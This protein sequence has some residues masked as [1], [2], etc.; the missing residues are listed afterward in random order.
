[1][2]FGDGYEE[3]LG[4]PID[5]NDDGT[6][7]PRGY[8]PTTPPA[9]S[10]GA[11]IGCI[12]TPPLPEDWQ[13]LPYETKEIVWEPLIPEVAPPTARFDAVVY[14]GNTVQFVNES[15]GNVESILWDFGD[16]QTST[17]QHPLHIYSVVGTFVVR[18]TISNAG[19][20]DIYEQEVTAA[21]PA[22]EVG[23][24]FGIGGYT[25]YFTNLSNTTAW[26][27]S[28]GDGQTS[29]DRNPKHI[30][31]AT[32][33]YEVTLKTAGLVLKKTIK[34]D[35]EILLEWDDNSGDED[36]FK[37]ERSPDGST[38]WTE[39]ADVAADTTSYGITQAKDGVD[40]V[41]MNFFRVYAYSGGGDSGYSNVTNVRCS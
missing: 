13:L 26:E 23:F 20:E 29:T 3:G 7:T 8:H 37:I 31:S 27:W 9:H 14:A 18:L 17:E 21:A 33:D 28:F 35:V 40:S 12:G 5:V 6:I 16:G 36:G 30:Y 1:M 22:P 34:I 2:G 38:D 41:V 4:L 25:V 19:G 15:L 11:S 39:I 32:G 10:S 24:D